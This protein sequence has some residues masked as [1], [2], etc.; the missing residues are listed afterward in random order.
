MNKTY[1]VTLA[2]NE[3]AS[4]HQM[5]SAGKAAARKLLHARILLKADARPEGTGWTDEQISEAL[6]V[7]LPIIGRVRQ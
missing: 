2:S 3:R 5:I 1:I 7:S 6:E 4:L